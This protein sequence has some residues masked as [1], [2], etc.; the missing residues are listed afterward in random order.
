[1][2]TDFNY[3]EELSFSL[4]DWYHCTVCNN[5]FQTP[6]EMKDHFEEKHKEVSQ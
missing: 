2:K 5:I 6:S 4:E 1:M 3:E